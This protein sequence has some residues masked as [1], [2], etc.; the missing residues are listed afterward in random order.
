IPGEVVFKMGPGDQPVVEVSN[1]SATATIVLQGAHLIAWAPSGEQQVI[2]LSQ[3]AKFAKGKSIRGGVPVCW[4]WFGPHE[5]SKDFPAHGYARMVPWNVTEVSSAKGITRIGFRIVQ[6]DKAKS[7]WP[8]DCE[9]EMV[10]SIGTKLGIELITRNTGKQAFVIGEA[11]H[12]Y[13]EVGD[14]SRVSIDGLNDCPY[15]DKVD[16]FKRKQQSGAVTITEEVDRIYLESADDCIIVDPVMQ[17]RIRIAKKGSHST[18][19]WN[20]WIEKAN[21]MGDLGPNGYL[22]MLCVESANAAEDVV[23][24]KPDKEHRLSVSYSVETL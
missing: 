12:T 18:V 15:L 4:P 21:Q 9:L 17:R 22:K 24:I 13:F 19:V 14:V 23:T 16:N 7:M 10:Y 1:Q 20:P 8:H 2:W 3:D 6:D 5:A 11:L